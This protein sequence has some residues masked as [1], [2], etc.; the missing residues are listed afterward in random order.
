MKAPDPYTST[1]AADHTR[2]PIGLATVGILVV[3]CCVVFSSALRSRFAAPRLPESARR[4]FS[5][6][7]L[8]PRP[9]S[10][11]TPP[12]PVALP[13]LPPPPALL[14]LESCDATSWTTCS[15][16]DAVPWIPDDPSTFSFLP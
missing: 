3:L 5:L 4:Y 10:P 16:W 9:L 12:P 7:V 2:I 14:A 1:E 13:A 11:F 15:R 8:G 6:L